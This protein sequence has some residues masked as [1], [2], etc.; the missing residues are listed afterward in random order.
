MLIKLCKRFDDLPN[1]LLYDILRLRAEVFVVEQ[2]WLYCDLDD[3]DE[4]AWHF[5]YIK[6]DLVVAYLRIIPADGINYPL[7][8]IGRVCVRE[9][10]RKEGY[11]RM[12]MEEALEFILNDLKVFEVKVGAQNYLQTFYQ[13]LGFVPVSDVYNLDSIPH[14]DMIRIAREG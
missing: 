3:Y 10:Y 5:V 11:G 6:D 4:R 2:E 14:I 8:S 1:K 7:L 13:S 9:K 12:I